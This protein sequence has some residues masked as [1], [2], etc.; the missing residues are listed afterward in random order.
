M[1]RVKFF[2]CTESLDV[3]S[4]RL[5]ADLSFRRKPESRKKKPGCRIESGMMNKSDIPELAVG[6]FN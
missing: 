3:H 2:F 6:Y 4:P 1:I 5:A